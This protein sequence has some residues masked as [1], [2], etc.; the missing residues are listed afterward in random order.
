M[1]FAANASSA[2]ATAQVSAVTP[3]PPPSAVWRALFAQA[4]AAA[5]EGGVEVGRRRLSVHA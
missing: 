1:P 4:M 2:A 5:R 3:C